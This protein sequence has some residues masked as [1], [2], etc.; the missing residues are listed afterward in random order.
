MT[1]SRTDGSPFAVTVSPAR[2]INTDE[3][4][5]VRAMVFVT[6]PAKRMVL[7]SET[8]ALFL[9]FLQPRFVWLCSW[10]TINP[11]ANRG[12]VGL[13]KNTVKTQLASIF[14]KTKISRQSQLVR[15]LERVAAGA[16]NSQSEE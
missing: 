5:P 16:T 12:D 15:L 2:G 8:Y 11:A 10:P 6:D 1:I 9:A 13:T 3:R 4:Q 14:G 7:R